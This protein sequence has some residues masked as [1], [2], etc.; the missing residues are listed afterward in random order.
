MSD[1]D[2]IIQTTPAPVLDEPGDHDKFAHYVPK[3][4]L[5]EAIVSGIPLTALCGKQWV[6]TRDGLKFPVCPE[7]K[8]I[9]EDLPDGKE[10][11]DG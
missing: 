3:D 11:S 7:C 9:Y 10:P 5:M 2:T 6:P 1:T 8:E 4:A